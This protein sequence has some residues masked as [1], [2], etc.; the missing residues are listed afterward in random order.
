[1]GS[2]PDGWWRDRPG[3]ARAL[4]ALVERWAGA[5]G[6]EV[7]LVFDRPGWSADDEIDRRVGADPDP[8]SLVVVT[9]DR[10][11]ARRVEVR[12]AVVTGAGAFRRLLDER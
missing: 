10:A 9:S 12:G 5:S 6:A 4:H 11:L 2:R 7:S 1:M 3:A 8:S